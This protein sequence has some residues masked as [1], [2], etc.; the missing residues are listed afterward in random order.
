MESNDDADA[1]ADSVLLQIVLIVVLTLI[2]AFFAM[3]EM[4]VISANKTRIDLLAKD[5]NKKAKLVQK[6]NENQTNFLSTIQ[7]GITLS[8]FFSSATAAGSIAE[9]LGEWLVNLNVS[10]QYAETLAIVAITLILSFLTLIF[11]ELLPKKIAL[12]FPE[13]ISLSVA[14]PINIIRF[15][16]KP[17]VKLLSG[18]CNLLA[19]E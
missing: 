13:K 10:I 19:K 14:R 2:N 17:I 3:S 12:A 6:L 16:T 11:G 8:G 18:T 15:L 7:V 1:D 9:L 4:A 5:G